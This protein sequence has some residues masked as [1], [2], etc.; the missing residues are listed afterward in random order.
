MKHKGLLYLAS[1]DNSSANDLIE[2]YKE[3]Y[4][5]VIKFSN[6]EP[7]LLDFLIYSIYNY[8]NQQLQLRYKEGAIVLDIHSLKKTTLSI[9]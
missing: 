3:I 4:F 7:V 8:N 1:Q 9:G 5:F 2:K 6:V